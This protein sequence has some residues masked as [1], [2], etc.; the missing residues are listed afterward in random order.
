MLRL[1]AAPEPAPADAPGASGGQFWRY[2]VAD[3]PLGHGYTRGDMLALYAPRPGTNDE[4]PVGFGHVVEAREHSLLFAASYVN[5][6]HQGVPLRLGPI[7]GGH[8]FGKHLGQVVDHA[9]ERRVRIDMGRDHGVVPG[10]LYTVLGPAVGAADV[11]GRSL[12]RAPLG[13]LQVVEVQDLHALARIEMGQAPASANAGQI[14]GMPDHFDPLWRWRAA[15]G[16]C[17]LR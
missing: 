5:I 15:E 8:H 9:Q 2:M 12:G 1:V 10:D 14:S 3:L 13:L 6:D 11:G 16:R 7:P 4:A 17:F